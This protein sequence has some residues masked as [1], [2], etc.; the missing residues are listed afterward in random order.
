[1]KKLWRKPL[2]TDKVKAVRGKV[3][4]I[5]DRCKGCGFCI[6]LCPRDVLV[7]SKAFNVKGYHPPEAEHEAVS[8][9]HLRAHET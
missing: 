4:I 2:D 8:Y 9:T 5:V 7:F 3:H 1:M 6:E